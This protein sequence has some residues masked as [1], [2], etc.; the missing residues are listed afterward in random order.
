MRRLDIYT[1]SPRLDSVKFEQGPCLIFVRF[2]LDALFLNE[3]SDR[4]EPR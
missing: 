2:A 1:K 4:V 3:T